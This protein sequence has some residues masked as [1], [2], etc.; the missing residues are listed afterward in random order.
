MIGSEGTLGIITKATIR[1][2]PPSVCAV[3]LLIPFG[4]L[5]NAIATVPAILGKKIVPMAVEFIE[6][7]S[8]EAA[9]NY[10]GRRWPAQGGN[11]YLMVIVDG[12]SEDEVLRQAELISELSAE[13]GSGEI[14]LAQQSNDQKEIL[15]F[16]SQLYETMKRYI[17]EVLDIVVPPSEVPAHVSFVHQ[18]SARTGLWLPTFGHASDGNIHTH[19]MRAWFRNGR[20]EEVPESVWKE[21]YPSV[22]AELH[23]DAK[24]R[25]GF[26]SGEHG[27][28]LV[29]KEYLSNFVGQVQ[30]ALFKKIKQAFD[31]NNILNPDKIISIESSS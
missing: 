8:I 18:V 2:L 1:L 22:R 11:A 27:I 21:K 3:T 13:M 24:A 14:Y 16:R 23:A 25:G 12:A 30:I 20:W 29:K 7:D 28:G 6:R 26:V 17:I 19:I 10:L 5:A 9:E 4:D 15:S 31:P